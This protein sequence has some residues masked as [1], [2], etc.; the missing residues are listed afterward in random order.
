MDGDI[1]IPL[2]KV[3]TASIWPTFEHIMANLQ[4]AVSIGDDD[5]D[6]NGHGGG[7]VGERQIIPP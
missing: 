5:C 6:N 2:K 4:S 1:H 3:E 7:G